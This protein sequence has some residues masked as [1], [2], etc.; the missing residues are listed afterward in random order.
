MDLPALDRHSVIP[1][2]IQIKQGL[3][4]RINSG[5]LRAG[6]PIPS[7][8]DLARRLRVSRMTARQALKSLCDLGVAYSQKGKGTFVSGL[9]AEKNIRQVLSFSQDT[10]SRGAKPGSRM[11]SFDKVPANTEVAKALQLRGGERVLRLRRVRLADGLPMGIETAYLPHKLFP[12]L[13]ERFEPG[14]SL[15]ETLAKSYA[16]QIAIADEVVE[17]G[18]VDKAD[19]KQLQIATG[20]P[21]FLFTRTSHLENGKPIEFV[22]SVYRG[23]HYKLVNRLTRGARG[24]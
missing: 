9:K 10:A 18:Q 14:G 4:D 13:M 5:D 1:L 24:I 12:D 21:V 17:A 2:Y 3:L 6:Q 15:Y 8:E 19:A 22:K 20:S 16:V 23:D 7:E 11:L